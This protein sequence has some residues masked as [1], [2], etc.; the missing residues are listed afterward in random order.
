MTTFFILIAAYISIGFV[1]GSIA[2]YIDKDEEFFWLFLTVWPLA[3]L[4]SIL[5]L[6]FVIFN[7]WVKV[8]T[9]VKE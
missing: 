2:A 1:L 4:V 9:K 3:L 5:A 7:A 8:I 6:I